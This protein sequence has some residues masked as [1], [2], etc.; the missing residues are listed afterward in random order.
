MVLVAAIV[1]AEK[2][3]PIGEQVAKGLAVVLVALGVWIALAPG[4]VPGLT[5]P[6]TGTMSSMLPAPV[7]VAS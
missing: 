3:L 6:G 1:F 4:S 7:E 5:R 2:A